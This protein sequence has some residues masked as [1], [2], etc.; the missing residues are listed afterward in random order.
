[1][2][3]AILENESGN[4]FQSEPGKRSLLVLFDKKYIEEG[5]EFEKKMGS[6]GAIE[7][8]PRSSG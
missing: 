2:S 7:Q 3:F 8:I 6:I 1:M 4:R 5:R